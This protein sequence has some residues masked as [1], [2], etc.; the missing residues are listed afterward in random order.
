ML[1]L[2]QNKQKAMKVN[3]ELHMLEHDLPNTFKWLK[4][5][6]KR[7][8]RANAK[9]ESLLGVRWNQGAAQILGDLRKLIW[10]SRET[11][12]NLREGD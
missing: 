11:H 2:P 9:Q 6:E 3:S 4:E 10:L 8:L 12:I 1:K 7:I 5:E